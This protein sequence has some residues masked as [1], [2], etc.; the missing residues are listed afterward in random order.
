MHRRGICVNKLSDSEV[1]LQSVVEIFKTLS[2]AMLGE[3]KGL[4]NRI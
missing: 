3:I 2:V 4:E 1:M